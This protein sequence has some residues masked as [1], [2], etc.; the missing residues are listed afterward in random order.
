MVVFVGVREIILLF[1]TINFSLGHTLYDVDLQA[2]EILI[3][4]DSL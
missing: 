2:V 1:S 3:K 4:N